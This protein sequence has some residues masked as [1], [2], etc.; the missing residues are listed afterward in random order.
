[1]SEPLHEMSDEQQIIYASI[2]NGKNV[3]VDACAGSGKSTTILS[4]AKKMPEKRFLQI[5]YNSMLRKEV[6]TKIKSLGLENIHVQTFHSLCVKYYLL[7]AFTDTGIRYVLYNKV[8]PRLKIPEIDILVLDEAQDMTYLYFQF[9][10][11]YIKDSECQQIQLLILGDYM[12]GLYEFKG[13]DIRFL[14]HADKIWKS[15]TPLTNPQFEK[16]TLRMSYRITK[17]MAD[18]VNQVMLGETRLLACKDGEQVVYIRNARH[19]LE[20]IVIVEIIKILENGGKPSDIFVLAASVKGINS[21]IRKMENALVENHIPCHVPMTENM[22]IDEKVIEGKVVFS[23]FHGVKG[24]QR[25]YVFVTNFDES[26]MNYFGRELDKTQCPNTLYVATTR[27][28]IGMYLLENDNSSTDRPLD[29][30]KMDH[31]TMKKQPFIRFKG[32]PRSIFYKKIDEKKKNNGP[33]KHDVTPTNLIRFLKESIIEEI[34]PLL[35]RIFTHISNETDEDAIDISVLLRTK[36]GF[37]EDISDLNGIA[38]PCIYYDYMIQKWEKE[39]P[40]N[41]LYETIKTSLAETQANEYTYLKKRINEELPK[42]CKT[43]SDYLYLANLYVAVQE[44]LYFKLKQI[45]LDEYNWLTKSVVDQCLSRF[46]KIIGHEIQNKPP[47]FETMIIRHDME[48][49]TQKLNMILSPHL[50]EKNSEESEKIFRFSAKTDLITET[51]V[52][53]LKCTTKITI[54]HLLQVVIYA[55]IWRNIYPD[56]KKD[57]KL[58]NI[59]SGE[60]LKLDATMKELT[61]IMVLLLKG[62]YG[63]IEKKTDDEFIEDCQSQVG[64]S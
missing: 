2:H 55:W 30:L 10:I 20:K 5:T 39:I 59:K 64:V 24:R 57:F 25:K 27:A 56:D 33:E 7:S 6:K 18:F 45:E 38:I 54:E 37:Y 23:T 13:S 60:I 32:I 16:C 50:Q 8:I 49:E 35:D 3:I 41:I 48:T 19:V 44:R 47:S 61:F 42:E 4:I 9:I 12:Q 17:P 40:R 28:T 21:H 15:F 63:K 51:S 1:M 26:Y 29:F 62:K 46:D 52:W 36:N 43:I 22:D 11:K 31:F 58:L 53:E 34:S 14:T